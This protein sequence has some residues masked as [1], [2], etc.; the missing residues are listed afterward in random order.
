VLVVASVL[1]GCGGGRCDVE[2]HGACVEFTYDVSGVPDLQARVDRLL[3]LELGY[4]GVPSLEGW[5]VQFRDTVEYQ[6]ALTQRTDGCTNWF[7]RE[8]SVFVHPEA[9]GCFESAE[10]LHELG[11]YTL[12]DPTHTDARWP[13][14]DAQFA[15]VVWDR[16]DAPADC[17]QRFHGV[18]RG[19]WTVNAG[20]F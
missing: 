14:L 17:R 3:A 11:H 7:R 6:C 15:A 10:L 16:P 20:G 5:K 12:R 1:G 4:W 13:A 9:G 8:L 19:M 18:Y 2:S